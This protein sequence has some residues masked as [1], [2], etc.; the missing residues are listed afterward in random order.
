MSVA[1]KAKIKL[2]CFLHSY[3]CYGNLCI[4]KM[5]TLCSPMI[6]QLFDAV[7]VADKERVV[8]MLI[9]RQNLKSEKCCKLFSAAAFHM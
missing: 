3:C 7:I 4:P 6:G 2:M 9:T 1:L 8:K 5:I